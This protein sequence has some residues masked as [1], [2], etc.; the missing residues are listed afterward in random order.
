MFGLFKSKLVSA[1]GSFIL[2]R[3]TRLQELVQDY[4]EHMEVWLEH[5]QAEANRSGGRVS[6]NLEVR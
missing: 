2:T 5:L 1:R 3:S 6:A 4:E